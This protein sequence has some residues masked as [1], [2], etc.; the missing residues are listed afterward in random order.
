MPCPYKRPQG[1]RQSKRQ[2]AVGLAY[3]VF[4]EDIEIVETQF[5]EDLPLIPHD[6]AH[7]P[8]EAAEAPAPFDVVC[9]IR[10]RMLFPRALIEAV[11]KLKLIVVTGRKHRTLDLA[12]VFWLATPAGGPAWRRPRRSWPGMETPTPELARQPDAVSAKSLRKYV[13]SAWP[14]AQ[15]QTAPCFSCSTAYAAARTVNA[16]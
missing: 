14:L 7:F 11:A 15:A 1:L 3:Q 13:A 9:H 2:F 10:E 12:A 6:E 8:A 4:V 5:P 16:M